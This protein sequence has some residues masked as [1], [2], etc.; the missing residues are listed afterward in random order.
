MPNCRA[1]GTLLLISSA[2]SLSIT[3]A[4]GVTA[5]TPMGAAL[6]FA[7]TMEIAGLDEKIN[8]VRVRSIIAAA[9]TYYPE[10]KASDFEGVAPWRGGA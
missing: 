1:I 5:V 2:T 7:G 9:T 10:I 4:S 6:R 3:F 8:P